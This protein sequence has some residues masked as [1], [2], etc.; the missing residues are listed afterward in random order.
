MHQIIKYHHGMDAD[1][2]FHLISLLVNGD[3]GWTDLLLIE[4]FKN[5]MDSFDT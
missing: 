2:I 4:K 5:Q 3:N 1:V